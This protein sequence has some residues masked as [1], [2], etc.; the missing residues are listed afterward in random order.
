ME[1]PID[2]LS[3]GRGSGTIRIATASQSSFS[4]SRFLE[5]A[6]ALVVPGTSVRSVG[7]PISIGIMA[8]IP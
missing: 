6:S 2:F 3:L 7:I 1:L 5:M 8:S 4:I